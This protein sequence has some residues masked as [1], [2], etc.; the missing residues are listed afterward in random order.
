MRR[1]PQRCRVRLCKFFRWVLKG[2][3]RARCRVKRPGP[4][5]GLVLL[6]DSP[7]FDEDDPDP[8]CC[9]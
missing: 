1:A 5:F 6:G 2:I 7:S 3:Y 9:V 8:H 4:A